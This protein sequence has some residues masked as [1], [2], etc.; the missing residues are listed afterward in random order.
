MD[1]AQI[2]A[3]WVV[4]FAED[5]RVNLALTTVNVPKPEP[6]VNGIEVIDR[7]LDAN[8]HLI[9]VGLEADV[10]ALHPEPV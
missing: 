9:E 10:G 3:S 5:E 2:L 1:A 6:G 4:Y 7:W 8:W